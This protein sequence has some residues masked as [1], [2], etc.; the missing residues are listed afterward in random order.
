MI[1]NPMSL[2][3][4]QKRV[5]GAN[6]KKDVARVSEFKTWVAFEEEASFLWKNAWH[7]NEDSS[8][9]YALATTLKASTLMR[10][11]GTTNLT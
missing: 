5:K 10:Y 2:T 6:S 8:D 3:L 1:P 11:T 9:I 7:Y 4:L